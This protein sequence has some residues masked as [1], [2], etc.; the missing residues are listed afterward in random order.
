[1]RVDLALTL[2]R[3]HGARLTGIFAETA[4]PH[5]VGTV[6]TWP[7][8][9]YAARAASAKAAFDEAAASLGGKIAFIDLNRGSEHEILARATDYARHFDLVMLGGFEGGGHVPPDLAKQ[10]L[11]ES[12]RPVLM[13]PPVGLHGDVGRRPLFAWH[14]SRAAARALADALPL[15]QAD[16]EALVLQAVRSG[17][18]ASEF[19]SLV[20]AE[21][22]AHGVAADYRTV[23]LDAVRLMDTLLNHAA[24]H[25]ADLLVIGAFDRSGLGL[26]GGG[27]GTRYLMRHMTLPVLFSH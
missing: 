22:A 9:D 5:R 1:M 3:R 17:E 27:A 4:P 18:A 10:I 13:V 19:A 23:S 26:F 25:A 14:R 12:G 24:D 21:L 2:A 16:A 7:S 20:L 11:L 15:I 8:A 6:A